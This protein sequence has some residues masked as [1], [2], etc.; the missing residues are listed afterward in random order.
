[1]TDMKKLMEAMQGSN[2]LGD[3]AYEE[4]VEDYD[5]DAHASV[6][7]YKGH[8]A[9]IVGQVGVDRLRIQFDSGNMMTV[10]RDEVE[11]AALV[12][13]DEAALIE[14]LQGHPGFDRLMHDYRYFAKQYVQDE[15]HKLKGDLSQWTSDNTTEVL[16]GHESLKQWRD[17]G[18]RLADA[19][20]QAEL[21]SRGVPEEL[22]ES[23][24]RV[25][26][27]TE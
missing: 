8:T 22:S 12:E 16:L 4:V 11:D 3:P 18:D 10:R 14:S 25:V 9:R 27:D 17:L 6:V 15:V 21:R 5:G 13:L 2:V 19:F 26:G 1:M 23:T 24:Q 7:K 20:V